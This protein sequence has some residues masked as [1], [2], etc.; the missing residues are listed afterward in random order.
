MT[1]TKKEI[2]TQT[3]KKK[4][5][6]LN[7]TLNER[8]RRLWAASEALAIGYA[9]Q[10][11]VVTATQISP[12]TIRSGIAEVGST[13]PLDPERIRRPGGGRKR[14]VD[15]D[16]TL[17]DDLN[18]LVDP[19]TRGDPMTALRWTAKSTETLAEA[20]A[21]QGH[22]ISPDSVGVLLKQQHYS[23]QSN[24][25][26]REGT[27]HPDRNAQFQFINNSVMSLQAEGQPTISID[28]KKKENVGNYKNNGQTWQPTGKPVEVN[29]H[30][31]PD[32]ERGKVAPYGVY[33]IDKNIG[34]VNIGIDHDTAE[35]AVASI[36]NWWHKLGSQLYPEATELLITADC[37]GSNSS[38]TR[39]WKLK[40]QELAD[41]L[42]L[43]IHVRH[44][45]P[46]T[47]KWN[48]IEHRLFSAITRNWRGQPLIDRATIVNL[49]ASTTTKTGLKVYAEIDHNAYPTGIK[50]SDRELQA[51]RLEREDWHGD[52]NYKV[53]PRN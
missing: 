50:V 41:E 52:W 2:L 43:I 20:L 7:P 32:K 47:S 28:T 31:F 36:G 4:Y 33:D 17:A 35:F 9:G 27:D 48:K 3:I 14:L 53:V 23:L 46:G 25:K 49:I 40:L 26:R 11:V 39:L 51:I 10:T 34:W 8:T 6:I 24:R 29:M 22:V 21:L 12:K 30:D 1:K 15:T 5:A 44:F 19:E 45:P 38:R 13:T 18:S 42:H 16:L 37:G